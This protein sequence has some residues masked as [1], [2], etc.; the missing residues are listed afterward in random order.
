MV[1]F[2]I[3]HRDARMRSQDFYGLLGVSGKP[4]K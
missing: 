3:K 4:F 2:L 1:R